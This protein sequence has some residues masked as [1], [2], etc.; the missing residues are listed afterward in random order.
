MLDRLLQEEIDKIYGPIQGKN[1]GRILIPAF[2][3]DFR[4]VL[5]HENPGVTVSEE[6][7]TEDKKMH[8]VLK[9]QRR[10]GSRGFDYI[11]LSCVGNDV[12][13]LKDEMLILPTP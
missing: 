3:G 13:L 11:V 12:E 6:Y 5:E 10:F 4:K 2:I 8:L 7:M 9:G 1:T